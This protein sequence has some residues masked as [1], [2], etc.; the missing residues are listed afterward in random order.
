MGDTDG[1][2]R[3]RGEGRGVASASR[4]DRITPPVR[5]DGGTP[6]SDEDADDDR[7]DAFA[8]AVTHDLR[9]PIDIARIRIEAARDTGEDV[10]FE[11]ALNA[12]DRIERI[13]EDVHA[14]VDAAQVDTEA[15]VDVGDVARRAWSTVETGAAT[16]DV[17]D[18]GTVEADPSALRRAFENLFRNSVEHG[19]TS[20]RTES[21]DSVEHGS[22]SSRTE[23][24]D[25]V[26]HGST[27]NR[28]ESG[29]ITVTVDGTDG[30]FYVEDDGVGVPPSKRE[31]VFDPGFSTK[32]GGSGMG[33]EI[34]GR[35]ADAHGWTVEMKEGEAGGARVAFDTR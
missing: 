10:H 33:L 23:S 17:A 9:N 8:R 30:G 20:S 3:S 24:D 2:G 19:S 31:R 34:V 29:D 25:S 13:V 35:I 7:L 16:L 4:A 27:G 32:E 22:T 18:P 6:P 11:K 28:T 5:A 21:D 12:V 14:V 15:D 1:V 26:E